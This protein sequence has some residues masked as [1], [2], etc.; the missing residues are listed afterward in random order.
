MWAHVNYNDH[1]LVSTTI[2]ISL[3]T[4]LKCLKCKYTLE[5]IMHWYGWWVTLANWDENEVKKK[6]TIH[7]PYLV[8]SLSVYFQPYAHLHREDPSNV[9]CLLIESWISF[10][11]QKYKC[12]YFFYLGIFSNTNTLKWLLLKLW[13]VFRINYSFSN[14]NFLLSQL[15]LIWNNGADDN[16]SLQLPFFL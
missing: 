4:Y 10:C 12:Q 14:W 15:C 7:W 13:D 11:K 16:G 9:Q 5:E 6:S 8:L 3:L 2:T 1:E